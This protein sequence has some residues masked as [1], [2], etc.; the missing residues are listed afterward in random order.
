MQY[1]NLE[2][3]LPNIRHLLADLQ[4]AQDLIMAEADPRRRAA[5]IEANQNRWTALRDAFE[6]AS[7]GKCWYTECEILARTTTSTISGRRGR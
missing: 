1:I 6:G 4:T 2:D 7:G 3:I 5:L